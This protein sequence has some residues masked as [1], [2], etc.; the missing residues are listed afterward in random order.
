MARLGTELPPEQSR[1]WIDVLETAL[2][3]AGDPDPARPC[4][5]GRWQKALDEA[6][7]GVTS[8]PQTGE[9]DWP[10]ADAPP[11]IPALS[12]MPFAWHVAR[13]SWPPEHGHLVD[14][15]L[16]FLEADVMLF[17]SGY[18]KK[19]LLKKQHLKPVLK[20]KTMSRIKWMKL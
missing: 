2:P 19:H 6:M 5:Y 4:A 15:T 14:F 13:A 12:L 10:D 18:L 1:F 11:P 9:Y 16:R 3:L 8:W 17:R 7:R 20:K